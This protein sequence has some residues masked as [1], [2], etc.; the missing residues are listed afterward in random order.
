MERRKVKQLKKYK[1]NTN[2]KESRHNYLNRRKIYLKVKSMLMDINRYQI[3]IK[4]CIYH[5]SLTILCF[6]APNKT[7][8]K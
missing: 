7:I 4:G 8:S 6:Y 3:R 1:T 5:D 2:L